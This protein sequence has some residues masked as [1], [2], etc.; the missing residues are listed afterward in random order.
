MTFID[1][2]VIKM[3]E[4][5]DKPA[6]VYKDISYSYNS[7]LTLSL[8]YSYQLQQY[9]NG[10]EICLVVSEKTISFYSSMMACFLSNLIYMPIN[11]RAPI[12]KNR[13]LIEIANPSCIIIGSLSDELAL[14]LTCLV[15]DKLIF[16]QDINLFIKL[17]KHDKKN[18]YVYL[19][20]FLCHKVNHK[21][22][23]KIDLNHLC[24]LF[25]TSGSTG[26]P[27]GVPISINNVSMYLSA[28][29]S[30]FEFSFSDRIAQICDIAFDLSMHEILVAWSVGA[31]LY[32]YDETR[33]F[34]LAHFLC[35]NKIS[36]MMVVPSI[37]PILKQ[38]VGLFS[39][40]LID[41]KSIFFCGELLPLSYAHSMQLLSP[42]AMVVNLY[43]PTEAT[44]ACAFHVYRTY[45]CYAHLTSVP[46]GQSLGLSKL[47]LS[48]ENELLISGGQVFKGYWHADYSARQL[49]Y[50]NTGDIMHFDP[51]YG[52]VFCSRKKD[53]W[54]IEGVRIEKNEVEYWLRRVLGLDEVYAV[55]QYDSLSFI[56][57]VYA[58]V[59]QD[60]FFESH[61]EI[62]K[63]VLP[64]A[65]IPKRLFHVNDIPKLA[66]DKVDYHSLS[67][68]L[69]ELLGVVK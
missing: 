14:A 27:K 36:H 29:L 49:T 55:V 42:D 20:S 11:T 35:E 66:N 54:K 26:V 18:K 44:I 69:S 34:S 21:A 64:K 48:R 32:V 16:I 61:Q 37:F 23:Y 13:Q 22:E 38:Y 52:Y 3:Q 4:N 28:I 17:S 56:E 47:S 57:G 51:V 50:Y 33:Y 63:T 65:V 8:T 62:L 53:T 15:V 31:S 7:L 58:F 1:K 67:R 40:S 5:L 24:Y 39:L 6:I 68:L 45:N 25:F 59:T 46:V 30:A 41:L 12:D 43:G 2:I 10:N 9:V 60:V 19:R